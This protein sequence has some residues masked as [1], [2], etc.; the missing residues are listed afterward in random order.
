MAQGNSPVDG[1]SESV[2]QPSFEGLPFAAAPFDDTQEWPYRTKFHVCVGAGS[3]A[4]PTK[5]LTMSAILVPIDV[6][7][8]Y[9]HA[10][11]KVSLPKRM[12]LCTPDMKMAI[13]RLGEA[14]RE[15]GGLFALSD[16]FRSYEMQLQ[17][18]LDYES[19]KKSAYSPRP[20]S[21]LHES[22][23]AFDVDLGGLKMGLDKFWTLAASVGVV[24][25]NAEPDPKL[26][27]AWH[28]ECR[29]SHQLVYDYY[30]SGKGKNFK[31]PYAAMAASAILA[32]G[33]RHDR[34]LE[35]A[36][37]ARLQ[38]GLIRLGYDIGN[39]DGAIGPRSIKALQDMGLADTELDQQLKGVETK[40]QLRFAEEYF[41][42]VPEEVALAP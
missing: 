5:E 39:L 17:A 12:A 21:S 16:L 6:P 4:Y 15:K 22:G 26:S 19:K 8:I 29:G 25:I 10:G 13:F 23:R 40:L 30:K 33:I 34:F 27:E 2:G 36:S 14:V 3:G 24:P 38:S 7:S 31:T 37:A 1:I 41:D 11:H 18:A 32:V 20:G 42:S 35:N 28:F 9:L